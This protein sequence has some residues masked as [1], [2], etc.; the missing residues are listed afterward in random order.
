MLLFQMAEV[1]LCSKRPFPIGS[2]EGRRDPGIEGEI[3]EVG[4][5]GADGS[6][7]WRQVDEEDESRGGEGRIFIRLVLDRPADQRSGVR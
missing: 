2:R 1:T 7:C 3:V 5:G 6:C 4:R